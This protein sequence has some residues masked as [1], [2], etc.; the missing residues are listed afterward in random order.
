MKNESTK[1]LA[2]TSVRLWLVSSKFPILEMRA[3]VSSVSEFRCT[4]CIHSTVA[5]VLASMGQHC[6]PLNASPPRSL[7]IW[8]PWATRI[9]A[10]TRLC[11]CNRFRMDLF[12]NIRST[13]SSLD[14]IS[15]TI[16]ATV[17]LLDFR[18]QNSAVLRSNSSATRKTYLSAGNTHRS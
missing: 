4:I 10:S 11:S 15:N 13:C 8:S 9:S 6:L 2:T 14:R 16:A 3:G 7:R 12:V 1:K 18:F 17:K 5:L